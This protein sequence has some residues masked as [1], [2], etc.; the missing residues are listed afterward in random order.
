MSGDR[1]ERALRE[2]GPRERGAS[3]PPLPANVEAARMSL[4]AIDRRRGLRSI[5]GAGL[6]TVAVATAAVVVAVALSGPPP[7]AT[8]G[9]GVPGAS[10]AASAAPGTVA[11]SA[12]P[13]PVVTAC[14][15]AD[16]AAT[17]GEWGAAAGSRGVTVTVTNTSAVACL[18]S[19]Y[20]GAR[21][22]NATGSLADAAGKPGNSP[23][24]RVA[25]GASV[26]TVVVWSNWC[27]SA[28]AG[29]IAITLDLPSG[30][31]AV[32]PDPAHGDVLVP[33]CMGPDGVN[34][35]STGDFTVP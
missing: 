21:L 6:G 22:T 8:T 23:A 29:P 25:A 33:P 1:T 19:G 11:P 2:R 26:T 32:T 28:P 3:I 15:P 35:L 7:A 27:G 4:R 18:L 5:I 20:P 13:S 34:T 12:S 30:Q 16:L 17:A 9:P 14:E 24:L 31:V 10:A